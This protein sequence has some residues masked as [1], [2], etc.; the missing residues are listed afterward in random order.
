MLGLDRRASM[1]ASVVGL[2]VRSLIVD[3]PVVGVPELAASVGSV[4]RRLGFQPIEEPC[5]CA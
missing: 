2:V 3:N 5:G 4:D 1:A